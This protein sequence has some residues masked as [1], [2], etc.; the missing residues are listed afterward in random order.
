MYFDVH[1]TFATQTFGMNRIQ[2]MYHIFYLQEVTMIKSKIKSENKEK[3]INPR[4]IFQSSI[5]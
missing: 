3:E 1:F 5:K 2:N 4:I